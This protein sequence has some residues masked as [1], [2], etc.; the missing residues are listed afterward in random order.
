[1]SW[2][3]GVDEPV[4]GG[5]VLPVVGVLHVENVLMLAQV[6]LQD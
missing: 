1:M 4:E 2:P 6:V 3:I 5:E